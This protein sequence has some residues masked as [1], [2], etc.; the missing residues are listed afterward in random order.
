[1]L[2]TRQ[3]NCDGKDVYKV[4]KE[5][6]ALHQSSI[7]ADAN[8]ILT[9][10]K[11]KRRQEVVQACEWAQCLSMSKHGSSYYGPT[12]R[13]AEAGRSLWLGPPYL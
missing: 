9:A 8:G 3:N 10:I 13:L 6:N 12:S 1:M 4:I 5:E 11:E 7:D 2:N